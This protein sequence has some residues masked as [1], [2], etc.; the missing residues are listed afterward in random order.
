[1]T[2][3]SPLV[4]FFMPVGHIKAAGRL[5]V[6]LI[7]HRAGADGHVGEQI[8][9][10]APVFRVEHLIRGGQAELLDGAHL[11]MAYGHQTGTRSGRSSGLGWK[12]MPL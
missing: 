6:M 2:E 1:M 3:K 11:Q 4:G 10:I 5:T 8:L 7:L 9:H 12:A